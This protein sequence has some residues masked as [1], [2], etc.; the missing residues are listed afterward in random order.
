MSSSPAPSAFQDFLRPHRRE[1]SLSNSMFSE[2]PK[3]QGSERQ[4][5][6]PFPPYVRNLVPAFG[7]PLTLRS[8]RPL[9]IDYMTSTTRTIF[10]LL[11]FAAPLFL[12]GCGKSNCPTTSLTQSG[13]A[14]GGAI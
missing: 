6:D 13:G 2:R 8:S 12:A 11:A 3:T 4:L 7:N 5:A 14:N 10:V 1:S 9:E